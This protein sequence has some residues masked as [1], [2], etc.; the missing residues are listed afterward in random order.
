MKR[1]RNEGDEKMKKLLFFLCL[2][3]M[4]VICAGPVVW[5]LLTSLKTERELTH[6]PPLLPSHPTLEHYRDVLLHTA[7]LRIIGNSLFVS[8]CA[9][10]A[11]LALGVSAGFALAK[12]GLRRAP[13]LLLFVLSASMLPAVA[14]VSPLYLIIR[15]LQLRDTLLS[16]ILV[17]TAFSLPLAIWVMTGFFRAL[18][19]ELLQAAFVDG[20]SFFQAFRRVML[21]LAA[22]GVGACGILV[23]LFCWN[24]FLFALTFTATEKARTIPVAIAT[25]PGLHEVPW[26]EISAAS[27]IAV[28]PALVF[29][30]L[31]Q[32]RIVDGLTAG[33]TKG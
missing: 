3:A 18:P 15:A 1:G 2:A 24:E 10:L 7:F 16:L 4:V 14:T 26:G 22:P 33:S 6:L 30:T 5:Q 27:M 23:F 9:T 12:G 20:C 25:F 29:V 11:A 28:L 8:F 32:R 13:V 19:D 31:F 21:P 17:Y